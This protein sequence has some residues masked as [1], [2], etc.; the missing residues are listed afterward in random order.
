VSRCWLPLSA[1]K[2]CH[3]RRREPPGP[4]D[5]RQATD[6]EGH[7]AASKRSRTEAGEAAEEPARKEQRTGTPRQGSG[8]SEERGKQRFEGPATTV[9]SG[10]PEQKPELAEEWAHRASAGDKEP[11]NF[12][13][14]P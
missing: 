2:S 8:R 11:K 5:L 10:S 13:T 14:V 4:T 9:V 7:G 3:D 1:R 12:K 6:R